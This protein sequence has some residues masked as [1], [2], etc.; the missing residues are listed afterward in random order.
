MRISITSFFII[1]CVHSFVA[2][3]DTI[4]FKT[5]EKDPV[6][7]TSLGKKTIGFI[8]EDTSYSVSESRI[9]YIK[10]RD[11]KKYTFQELAIKYD[12]INRIADKELEQE[13]SAIY[14]PLHISFGLGAGSMA[15]DIVNNDNIPAPELGPYF[16]SYSPAY[17]FMIDYSFIKWLS[18]G[19]GA[20]Y[21][22][23]ND[24]PSEE[25]PTNKIYATNPNELE[26]ISRYNY[27]ARLLYHPLKHS[28]MDVYAGIR[29]GASMWKEQIVTNS[30]PPADTVYKTIIP[31]S[32]QISFQVVAGA[33]LPLYRFIGIHLE[34]AYGNPYEFE[35][36]I[37][38][39][40][41]P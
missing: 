16:V 28:M 25:L 4:Y 22:Y 32:T 13:D 34:L 36:G 19:L 8:L 17:N 27:S 33:A 12:S 29:L 1:I 9:N 14:H 23:I 11:G 20:V 6:T 39:M 38:F 21:Q 41:R 40:L 35:G 31:S 10:Y 5:G 15:Q 26:K 30:Q 24:N 37:T 2:A 3:Q 7:V 18:F